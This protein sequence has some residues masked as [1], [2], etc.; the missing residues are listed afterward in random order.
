MP[1][2]SALHPGL[3][4]RHDRV[5][6][7]L[8]ARAPEARPANAFE[9]RERLRALPWPGDAGGPGARA[10]ER[11]ATAHLGEGR[12]E[13]G[14]GGAVRDTWT[15]RA[16][17]RVPL[18]DDVLARARLFAAAAHDALQPVLRVDREGRC[19]W[20]AA[21]DPIDRPPTEAETHRLRAAIEALIVA[22]ADPARLDPT[23]LAVDGAGAVVLR[24]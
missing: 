16:I 21:C 9:A 13:L 23:V 2:L 5:V 17:E 8:L 22:G 15:G 7:S 19:L 14:P 10:E 1:P 12:L 11:G 6:A 4:A 20:L 3:D 18:S 24:F